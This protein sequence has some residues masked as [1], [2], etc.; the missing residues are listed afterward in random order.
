MYRTPAW[1]RPPDF[2]EKL[3]DDLHYKRER[4]GG[5]LGLRNGIFGVIGACCSGERNRKVAKERD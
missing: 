4:E 1:G 2:A 3:G 5:K